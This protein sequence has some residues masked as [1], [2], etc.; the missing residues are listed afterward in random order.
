[1]RPRSLPAKYYSPDW[2]SELKTAKSVALVSPYQPPTP[3]KSLTPKELTSL[4]AVS[5]VM[6]ISLKRTHPLE[7]VGRLVRGVR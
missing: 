4:P 6:Y 1:M 2:K 3:L 7:I 5:I